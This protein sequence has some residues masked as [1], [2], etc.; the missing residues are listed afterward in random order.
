LTPEA[1][2]EAPRGTPLIPESERTT[3][4]RSLGWVDWSSIGMGVAKPIGAHNLNGMV[5]FL[6]T[7]QMNFP[8]QLRGK[9]YIGVNV[10]NIDHSTHSASFNL[11]DD[12]ST[13][14]G[15]FTVRSDSTIVIMW[16]DGSL[17]SENEFGVK[18]K[19]NIFIVSDSSDVLKNI[20]KGQGGTVI[21][22]EGVR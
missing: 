15:T 13:P 20:L 19:D 8:P 3:D 11:K 18:A 16:S 12:D 14:L 2:K 21:G 22:I 5:F 17:R 9:F 10:L 1:T 7:N 4:Y 6:P